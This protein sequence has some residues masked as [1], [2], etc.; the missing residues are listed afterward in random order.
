MRPSTA[1]ETVQE[2][3]DALIQVWEEIP[4]DTIR[5]LIRS[6]PR[7]CRECT[8]RQDHHLFAE[9]RTHQHWAGAQGPLQTLQRMFRVHFP[10]Q[11]LVLGLVSAAVDHHVI[12]VDS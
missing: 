1:T 6:M 3:T 9:V 4:Q 2:L 7:H 10:L 8:H 12:E 5:R 11:H